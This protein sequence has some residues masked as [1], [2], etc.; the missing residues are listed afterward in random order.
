[1]IHVVTPWYP[2]PERP[3]EGVFVRASVAALGAD[4]RVV[5]VRGVPDGPGAVHAADG[6][7][8]V[9]RLDVPV[10]PATPRVEVAERHRAAL[11]DSGVLDGATTVLAHVGMP[12][13]Y[14]VSGILEPAA[15]LVVV[16][17]ASYLGTVLRSPA[18]HA[19][20]RAMLARSAWLL[21]PTERWAADLRRRFPE[22]AERIGVLGNPVDGDT[23]A[24]R[25]ERPRRLDRWVCV[26]NL[27]AH[28][29]VLDVLEAFAALLR[30]EPGRDA[31]LTFAGEGPERAELEARVAALGLA[32][33]VSLLGAVTDVPPVMADADVLVHLSAAETF[34]VGVVEAAACGLPVVVTRC[35]GP[36][37]TLAGGD[38]AFV[39]NP[40]TPDQVVDA[41]LALE[42][43]EPV[44]GTRD[45]VLGRY[46]YPAYR[47]R[48]ERA[49]AG[50]PLDE[51]AAGDPV[52]VV[53]RR[54]GDA[55]VALGLVLRAGRDAVLV[56][57]DPDLASGADRRVQVLTVSG[58]WRARSR[59]RLATLPVAATAGA[60]RVL[61]RLAALPRPLGPLARR[62]VGLLAR[63]RARL[64]RASA[65]R[66]PVPWPDLARVRDRLTGPAPGL[67]LVEADAP[68]P[69]WSDA[70]V[71]DLADHAPLRAYLAR[72]S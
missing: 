35:G 60:A 69:S 32:G 57:P 44:Q 31:H 23:F 5:H 58:T 64:E 2:T 6:P 70:P 55:E 24:P 25:A 13:G 42:A 16:E 7:D 29:R 54:S 38:V 49:M 19:A 10:P 8:G 4:A 21:V 20:Y 28:K 37:E 53:A 66:G 9:V 51:P 1:V 43:R 15:R 45:L 67:W 48:L 59:A 22:Q 63:V 34:G 33:R 36:E 17:H 39:P 41:V 62:G 11:L 68:R 27:T 47:A 46:G 65:R 18:G 14:A 52:A 12:S 72:G 56:T 71:L 50:M 26:G 30:R 3:Y 61:D 40:P